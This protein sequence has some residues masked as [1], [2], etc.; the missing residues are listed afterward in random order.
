MG[1]FLTMRTSYAI[2]VLSLLVP[3]ALTGCKNPC[4]DSIENLR[5][6][7][8]Q[9][10]NDKDPFEEGEQACGTDMSSDNYNQ[11]CDF[12]LRALD[13]RW[14]YY[15]CTSCDATEIKLCSCYDENAWVVDID[16]MPE[17]PGVIYC[18]AMVYRVR[19]LC[20]CQPCSL[21]GSEDCLDPEGQFSY[22]I[23]DCY[24][25]D[26]NR[27][28]A[29][30]E[31]PLL[32][33]PNLQ[34]TDTCDAILSAFE[35]VSF[36]A[37][38]DGIPDQYDGGQDRSALEFA[39]NVECLRDDRGRPPGQADWRQWF[40]DPLSLYEGG[41]MFIDGDGD[42]NYDDGDS[43]QPPPGADRT[44]IRDGV[45]Q[46]CDNCPDNPNG[47]NCILF[48]DGE[49]AMTF[50]EYC[51]YNGDGEVTP[52]DFL[53]EELRELEDEERL[54]CRDFLNAKAPF[55]KYCDVNGDGV[56][57]LSEIPSGDQKDSDDDRVGDACDNCP[58]QENWDQDDTD[59]D[60]IGDICDPD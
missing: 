37:D 33:H 20:Q 16:G 60:G 43:P 23:Y 13:T 41:R 2:I 53:P 57:Q 47:F 24:D 49:D 58:F 32:K 29:Q 15:D 11:I 14:P 34:Q 45:S 12:A 30:P 17:Y 3:L 4:K 8:M 6:R 35:C 10:I 42:G 21:S 51:D 31:K 59:G 56:T 55:I 52:E 36:D 18:L 40:E 25:R 7:V 38:L 5:A 46:T 54:R 9:F 28:C 44:V 19:D 26:G 1:V 48:I 39:E 50:V 22:N 27:V